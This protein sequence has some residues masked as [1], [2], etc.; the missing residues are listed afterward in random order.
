M[1]LKAFDGRFLALF[2][3]QLPPSLDRGDTIKLDPSIVR[4]IVHNISSALYYLEKK[5]IVHHDLKPHNIAHS[6][7]R[8]A[9]LLDFGQAAPATTSQEYGGTLAFLPPEFP[10]HRA[11]GHAGDVWA[12]GLT[13]LYLLGKIPMPR[14]RL[15][16][17]IR[18]LYR[19]GS[20]PQFDDF[21]GAIALQRKGLNL[22]DEI[23]KLAFRMLDPKP[24]ARAT[25]RGIVSALGKTLLTA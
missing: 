17:R 13:T 12:L 6:P 1:S 25:A 3:E 5:G 7:A 22:E 23:E 24:E 16:V 14:I 8:G 11:R 15:D 10:H 20:P 18:D 19:Y 4:S 9:V 2:L 21:M